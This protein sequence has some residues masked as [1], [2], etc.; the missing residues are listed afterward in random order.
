MAR[1]KENTASNEIVPISVLL[2]WIFGGVSFA[3][4]VYLFTPYTHNLDDIKVTLQYVLAPI[5]WGFFAVALISGHIRRLH[6]VLLLSVMGF[7]LLFVLSTIL[8]RFPWRAWHDLGFHLTIASCFVAVAGTA[9]T[10][11]RFENICLFYFLIGL[12]TVIFGLFHYFGGIKFLFNQ[13]FPDGPTQGKV[14]LYTLLYTLQVTDQMLSTIL[15]RDFYPAYLLM[16]LPL[17][18]AMAMRYQETK[19]KAF[20]LISFLLM[21]VCVI[22][23]FSKDTYLA[24]F[25]MTTVFLLLYVKGRDLR[26]IP[27][28]TGIVWAVGGA[29][30]LASVLWVVR[31]K[32]LDLGYESELSI[33]NRG[34]IWNGALGIWWDTSHPAGQFIKHVLIGGGPGTYYLAF[35]LYRNPNYHLWE[36]SNVTLFSH[37]QYLDLLCEEGLLGLLVFLVFL[38]TIFRLL[39]RQIWQKRDHPLHVYQ[40]AIFTSLVGISF[41]NF[42]SPAIRWTVCGFNYWF[43]LGLGTAAFQLSYS[44]EEQARIDAFYDRFSPGLKRILGRS[45]FVFTLVFMAFSVPYGLIYFNAAKSNND[46]LLK[47][48]NFGDL[49][50]QVAAN[51]KL[52]TPSVLNKVKDVGLET[53]R[54]FS[55]A[56]KWQ[57]SY[58]T[59]YYKLA[60][61]YS[62]LANLLASQED[63]EIWWRRAKETYDELRKYAPDYSEIH[64]NYGI[65]A[66]FFYIDTRDP[67]QLAAAL[68]SFRRAAEMSNKLAVQDKYRDVLMGAGSEL[69][70]ASTDEEKKERSQAVAE[71]LPELVTPETRSSFDPLMKEI[72]NLLAAGDYG[73]AAL[74]EAEVLRDL[75]L[76]VAEHILTLSNREGPAGTEVIIK[77]RRALVNEYFNRGT[78]AKALPVLEDMLEE[79]TEGTSTLSL[80]TSAAIKAGD[81]RRC[82]EVLSKI[83]D[84][85]PGNWAARDAAAEVLQAHL[86]DYANALVQIRAL[87][88]ILDPAKG[89]IPPSRLNRIGIS[90]AEL[91]SR[92]GTICER[93]ADQRTGN[94]KE[95]EQLLDRAYKYYLAAFNLDRE[96][97]WGKRSQQGINRL[98]AKMAAIEDSASTASKSA[99]P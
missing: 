42:F 90:M 92:A 44:K 6:P 61:V 81:P 40:I 56:L 29:V 86:G 14:S 85:N 49:C 96:G 41:Q 25:L 3:L 5:V 2:L 21:S 17:G 66:W 76:T 70:L 64:F 48:Q 24:L 98:V 59:S 39:F 45:L 93:L 99:Q 4:I 28:R 53:V 9:S 58:I 16:I 15:N 65:L 79:D 38:G 43:L 94:P 19:Y 11:K 71:V 62:R 27:R 51:P 69:R 31:E 50:D 10:R 55:R 72:R 26:A 78:Y 13:M 80:F 46:G 23:A 84:R 33:N 7:F 8:A 35:P 73:K 67:E 32:F 91:N 95:Q 63:S 89:F 34:I 36:I 77:T 87:M 22:L 83:I 97:T 88:T 57:P 37:N 54:D 60:H 18:I 20:F 30:V 12:G 1:S 82:L 74:V 68:K 52:R 47:L 75:A